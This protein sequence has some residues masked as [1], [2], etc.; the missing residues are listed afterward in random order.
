MNDKEFDKIYG[1]RK[2]ETEIVLLQWFRDIAFYGIKENHNHSSHKKN[3]LTDVIGC[4][5]I[6]IG[7]HPKCKTFNDLK[8]C[9][10]TRYNH[11]RQGIIRFIDKFHYIPC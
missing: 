11:L 7:E 1:N 10:T 4:L 9:D 3:D 2:I 6:S 8:S 5:S